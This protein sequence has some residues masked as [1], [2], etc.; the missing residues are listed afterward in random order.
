MLK[1]IARIR[2]NFGNCEGLIIIVQTVQIKVT[3]LCELFFSLGS[4]GVETSRI[5]VGNVYFIFNF[6][7]FHFGYFPHTLYCVFFFYLYVGDWMKS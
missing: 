7:L 4:P 2:L 3:H 1:M 5:A 6:F